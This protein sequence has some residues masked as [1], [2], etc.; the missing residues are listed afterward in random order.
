MKKT[1]K[2]PVAT[3]AKARHHHRKQAIRQQI[4][5]ARP[6]H[7]RLVLH[8]ATVF[9]LLCAGVFIISWTYGAVADSYTVSAK[10]PAPA[11][12]EGAVIT[13]PTNGSTF[14]NPSIRVSGTCPAGSYIKIY[15]N[16]TLGGV[17]F[18]TPDGSFQITVDQYEG[19][20]TLLTQAYNQ[21]DDQGPLTPA[22]DVTY[23]PPPIP[24]PTL[25]LTQRPSASGNSVQPTGAPAMLLTSDYHYQTYASGSDFV[26]TLDIE[27]GS[28]PYA[29]NIQWGDAQTGQLPFKAAGSHSIRHRYDK[30]GYYP[31]MITVTDHNGSKRFL[32]LAT[33]IVNDTSIGDV[34]AV[35]PNASTQS[36]ILPSS[37]LANFLSSTKVWLLVAWPSFLLVSIMAYSFWLGERQE[38]HLLLNGGRILTKRHPT[39]RLHPR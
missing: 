10:V 36:L 31:I 20:N 26:G 28:S 15:D 39:H 6:W 17:V 8:P 13:A 27:G 23:T 2:S 16:N 3:K 32:Q 12:T 33:R 4:R 11:L 9:T 21:T 5:L 38:F 35:T 24:Q 18:C 29:G 22:V 30:A 19:Q 14:N 7:R 37:D 1:K 34:S 25:S